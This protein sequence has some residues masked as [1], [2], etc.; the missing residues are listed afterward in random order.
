MRFEPKKK[1]GTGSK[2][3]KVLTVD[4]ANQFLSELAV[5][6]T[7]VFDRREVDAEQR[8]SIVRA[9][10][11]AAQRE[12]GKSCGCKLAD[13]PTKQG[14]VG[15]SLFDMPALSG[16]PSLPQHP[17]RRQ[18]WKTHRRP[19]ETPPQF[20]LRVYKPYLDKGMTKQQLRDL[21]GT[22]AIVL[23]KWC[24]EHGE[25]TELE[26]RLLTRRGRNAL[27]SKRFKSS[28]L[29]PKRPAS[30]ELRRQASALARRGL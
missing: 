23:Y 30:A 10:C 14:S 6:A 3:R 13:K 8:S 1:R 12:L 18:Y 2:T 7:S 26:D 17:P 19:N 29:G 22:L 27:L 21:D 16:P 15:N 25:P 28:K 11:K 9:V 24:R 5:T 20:V 4:A